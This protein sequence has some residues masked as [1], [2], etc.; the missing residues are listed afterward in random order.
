MEYYSVMN[1]HEVP[2]QAT[3]WMNLT[4]FTRVKK[5][6]SQKATYCMIPHLRNIQ[7]SKSTETECNLMIAKGQGAARGGVESNWL[8]DM[9]LFWG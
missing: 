1:R 2:T 7:T 4:D 3:T 5:T 9:G 8:I 6:H